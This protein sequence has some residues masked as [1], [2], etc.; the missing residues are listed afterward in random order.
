MKQQLGRDKRDNLMFSPMS[1]LSIVSTPDPNFLFNDQT[2][3]QST[4]TQNKLVLPNIRNQG[5]VFESF[6]TKM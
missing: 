6:V 2:F 1:H 5:K 4:K 3:G